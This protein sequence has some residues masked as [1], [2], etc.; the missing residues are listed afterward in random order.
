MATFL[1]DIER[2]GEWADGSLF[3]ILWREK[4]NVLFRWLNLLSERIRA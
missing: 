3:D 4:G 1:F 2:M